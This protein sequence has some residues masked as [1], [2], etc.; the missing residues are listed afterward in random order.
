M[1]G[2][3]GWLAGIA[4][5][6][7]LLLGVPPRTATLAGGP[8]RELVMAYDDARA[9]GAVAFPTDT[10]ESVVR[11]Q[12]PDG[13][14]RPLRLRFARPGRPAA[15]RSTS[16][17][18]RCSR[19]RARRSARSAASCR[20]TDVSDGKDGR[21]VVEDLVDLKPLKGIVWVGVHRVGGRAQ[22]LGEQRRLG[23]GVRARQRSDQPDGPAADQ[24]HADDPPRARALVPESPARPSGRWHSS[25][26]AIGAAMRAASQ[27]P[28]ARGRPRRGRGP[29]ASITAIAE[30]S[31]QPVPRGLG[32][33]TRARGEPRRRPPRSPAGRRPCPPPRARWPPLT[34]TARRP[35]RSTS[36]RPAALGVVGRRHRAPGQRRRL[37]RVGGH[38]RRPPEQRQEL[39]RRTRPERAPAR[40][41]QD[42]VDDD[43][44]A[45]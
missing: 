34:R 26:T 12:L 41:R 10:Y 23:P 38:E 13:E 35:S 30:A 39:A 25:P 33:A 7:S 31:A 6:A 43:G 19:P 11:F 40:G 28:A 27:S 18:A 2:V 15:W 45:A 3:T 4:L 32:P 29:R 8:T 1:T 44:A 36:C 37:A 17:A 22:H 14:H 5:G 9:S 24:A 42:R 20:R 16:T 21:W